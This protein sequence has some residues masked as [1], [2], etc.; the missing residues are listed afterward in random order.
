MRRVL[1]ALSCRCA[2]YRHTGES[3]YPGR[4]C[5][6]RLPPFPYASHQRVHPRFAGRNADA[7]PCHTPGTDAELR[8]AARKMNIVSRETF[9]RCFTTGESTRQP[10]WVRS[11][12]LPFEWES[13]RWTLIPYDTMFIVL[14]W[15]GIVLLRQLALFGSFCIWRRSLRRIE[16]INICY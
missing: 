1:R 9:R 5:L 14:M 6:L 12:V 13:D 4:S 8:R 16:L 15:H 3:R 2:S 10:N 11:A 7:Q